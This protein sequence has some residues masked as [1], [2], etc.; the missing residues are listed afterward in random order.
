MKCF[1]EILLYPQ[2]IA[3]ALYYTR[4]GAHSFILALLFLFPIHSSYGVPLSNTPAQSAGRTGQVPCGRD[5]F[6]TVPATW[7]VTPVSFPAVQCA[8]K[9]NGFGFPNVNVVVEP[10]P[11][12]ESESSNDRRIQGILESYRSVGLQ[13]VSVLGTLPL[14][15]PRNDQP[16]PYTVSFAITLQYVGNQGTMLSS[17]AFLDAGDRRYTVTY[18]DKKG[19]NERYVQEAGEILQSVVLSDEGRA[20]LSPLSNKQKEDLT[21][22][23]LSPSGGAA[24]LLGGVLIVAAIITLLRMRQQ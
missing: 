24:L 21:K 1:T 5:L 7:V 8:F 16:S 15:T 13:D 6:I 14:P 12:L 9:R 20:G 11:R 18:L 19:D 4:V 17:V 2:V 22:A 10:A 23:A 3:H